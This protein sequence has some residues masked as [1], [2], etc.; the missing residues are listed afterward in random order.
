MKS[1]EKQWMDV[2]IAFW[3]SRGWPADFHNADCE[4]WALWNPE[5]DFTIEWWRDLQLPEL[6]RWIATRP[7]SGAVLTER[8][9]ECRAALTQAWHE[10]CE[11]LRDNDISDVDWHQI[12]RFPQVVAHIKP[13][14][15]P[16][17]T[18]KFCHFLLPRVFPVVDSLGLGDGWTYQQYFRTV[19]AEWSS[20]GPTLKAELAYE[21]TS[22]IESRGSPV[23]SGFP[24]VNKVAELVL[25]GRFRMT[26]R[27]ERNM[28]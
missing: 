17:F 10:V 8:F 24:M 13:T 5:R 25:I 2:G 21:L 1:P 19:R 4:K 28:C 11:P 6:R 3:R 7:Y 22:L 9:L 18:S 20:F 26:G 15:S 12:E 23:Y 14:K 16:V 27:V